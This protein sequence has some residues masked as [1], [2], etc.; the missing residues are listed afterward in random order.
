MRGPLFPLAERRGHFSLS[1]FWFSATMAVSL[2]LVTAV[3]VR[4]L[5]APD[6]ALL[7]GLPGLAALIGVPNAI[8][9]GVYAWGGR[10]GTKRAPAR[11]MRKS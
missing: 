8:L 2:T 11:R 3:T 6:L 1:A 9:A 5:I 4:L 7:D 10:P